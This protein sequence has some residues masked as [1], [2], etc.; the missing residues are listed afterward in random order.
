V[1]KGAEIT[2]MGLWM[3]MMQTSKKHR[4]ARGGD[5]YGWA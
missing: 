1:S 5:L 4:Q 2:D 3:V